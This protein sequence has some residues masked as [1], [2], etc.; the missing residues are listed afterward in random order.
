[1]K[2]NLTPER[3]LIAA[4]CKVDRV[5]IDTVKNSLKVDAD[6]F[7]I[8]STGSKRSRTV[9]R[10]ISY[11]RIAIKAFIFRG[12]YSYIV[13]WQ[14][15]IG[16]YYGLI[17][18]FCVN[19]RFV[20]VSLV[21]PLIYKPRAGLF[22]CVHRSLFGYFLDSNAVDWFVCHSAQERAFY[23]EEFGEMHKNKI[24]FIKYGTKMSENGMNEE[25]TGRSRYFFSGG[26]SNR[27]YRTLITAFESLDEQLKIACQPRDVKG[28]KISSNIEVFHKVF[29]DDFLDYMRKAYAVIIALDDPQISSGQLVLLDAM[30][31]GKAIIATRGY[32]ME[33]YV[34]SD[35]AILVK[36]HSEGDLREAV[37]F[38]ANNGEESSRLS[39]NA[40]KRYEDNF[41]IEKFGRR[42][43]NVLIRGLHGSGDNHNLQV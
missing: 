14:Q 17:A 18:R 24:C 9:K 40:R 35:H 3:L 4:D 11:L 29:R 32:G 30:R 23:I 20:P 1:M 31:M 12:N 21:L 2:S 33:D 6:I 22:G 43:A 5:F 7:Y 42:I 25:L 34:D 36:P 37:S 15:F 10:H 13:F 28:L 8:D 38:L 27:D 41:T 19:K 16:F 39:S 26:T